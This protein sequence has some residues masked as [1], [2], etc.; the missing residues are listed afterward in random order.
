MLAHNGAD[1]LAKLLRARPRVDSG[2]QVPR[3][4]RHFR[5]AHGLVVVSFTTLVVTGFALKYPESWWAAPLLA[6]E[7]QVALRGWLHRLAGVV[8]LAALAYHV[9]H[10]L[11]VRRDRRVVRELIPTM[12]DAR[13]L[14]A[15]FRVNL[16]GRGARPTFGAFSYAEKI[17]YWAFVWGTAVMAVSGFILWFENWS[18]RN[19][20]KWV[21]DAATAI[22]WYEA[23]LA[24]LAIAVWHF[25]MVIFDPD[26]YPMDRA[27]I[28]GRTS[29]D[30]LRHTRPEYYREVKAGT[31]P[32]ATD[33]APEAADKAPGATDKAPDKAPEAA[34]KAPGAADE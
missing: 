8:L 13:D 25:Y 10:L 26:V 14:A 11:A 29:G 21:S 16:T 30:H 23:I 1:F 12:K 31:A 4:N 9:A 2:E 34:D 27:W 22:H 15:M 6:F 28:T 24:S 32:G 5:R 3:M 7:G 20:P 33:R 18:L 17:E 19:L